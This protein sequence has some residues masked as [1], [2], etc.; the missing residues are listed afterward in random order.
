[1]S[2]QSTGPGF[3]RVPS[4]ADNRQNQDTMSTKNEKTAKMPTT[5]S[6]LE[7][8]IL[9]TMTGPK[10]VNIEWAIDDEVLVAKLT[11]K[12]NMLS[13]R[14]RELEGKL[15]GKAAKAEAPEPQAEPAEES[16]TP[17]RVNPLEIAK[18]SPKTAERI[19][20]LAKRQ[21]KK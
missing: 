17:T 13:A 21:S 4:L 16:T 14:V 20:A 10:G 7:A 18:P 15:A 2:G 3:G 19:A 5:T 12:I 6:E 11:T 8:F 9:A 1:M